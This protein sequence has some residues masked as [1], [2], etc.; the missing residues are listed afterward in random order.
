MRSLQVRFLNAILALAL[1]SALTV[2]FVQS[3]LPSVKLWGSWAGIG[4]AV[5]SVAV[6]F[7]QLKRSLSA[8]HLV[9]FRAFVFSMALRVLM[10]ATA[11]LLVWQTTNWDLRQYLIL[12]GLTYPLFLMI[13]AYFLWRMLGVSAGEN[14]TRCAENKE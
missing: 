3:F 9:F 11:S 13:E 8:A 6:S 14:P 4:V 7:Y 12:L 10:I 1:L 2:A 5:A